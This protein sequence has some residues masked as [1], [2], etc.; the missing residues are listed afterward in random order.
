MLQLIGFRRDGA[1]ATWTID[2]ATGADL[3]L[4]GIP[5]LEW[6][7]RNPL[8]EVRMGGETIL[9]PPGASI[10]G[11]AAFSI[12]R[13]ERTHVADQ[14][15]KDFTLVFTWPEIDPLLRVDLVFTGGCT[16]SVP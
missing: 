12:P 16:L 8:T 5:V 15:G 6:E 11:D 13:D 3:Y 14:S 2:N 4:E 1:R 9:P 7:D 10:A